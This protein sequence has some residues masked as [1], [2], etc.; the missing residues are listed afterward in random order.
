LLQD[1]YLEGLPKLE[2]HNVVQYGVDRGGHVVQ[3]AR[4]ICHDLID[5][6]HHRRLLFRGINREEAL[7]MKRR[8]ADE[9]GDDDCH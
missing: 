7:R 5:L 3:Y 1:A 6:E 9:E 8:P 4:D 2:R